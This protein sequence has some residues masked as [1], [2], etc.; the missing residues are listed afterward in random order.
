MVPI[1]IIIIIKTLLLSC[2]LLI[3]RNLSMKSMFGYGSTSIGPG[4]TNNERYATSE[5]INNSIHPVVSSQ[6]IPTQMPATP[7]FNF[8][9]NLFHPNSSF[10][11]E[12]FNKDTSFSIDNEKVTNYEANNS[13]VSML[14]NKEIDSVDNKNMDYPVG[15][16]RRHRTLSF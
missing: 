15:K 5:N 2:A 4:P 1:I 3:G 12:N 14:K 8:N 13:L 9:I 16:R 6:Y 10:S 11:H 7:K